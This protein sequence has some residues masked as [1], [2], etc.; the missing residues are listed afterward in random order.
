MINNTEMIKTTASKEKFKYTYLI[1]LIRNAD[2][3]L[4]ELEYKYNIIGSLADE[5]IVRIATMP[6]Y[7]EDK[8]LTESDKVEIIAEL[9]EELNYRIDKMGRW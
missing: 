6:D 3:K 1:D 4:K 8:E 9:K 7:M 2:P 5:S